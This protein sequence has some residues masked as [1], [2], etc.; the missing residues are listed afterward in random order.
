[1]Y[2]GYGTGRIC[3]G[4]GEMI[5][6]TQVEYESVY[7]D[8]SSAHLHLGC[9]GLLDAERRRVGQ[10]QEARDRAHTP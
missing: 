6:K 1:M 4:C 3:D 8:N 7:Q 9:A 10:I 5:E 2:A